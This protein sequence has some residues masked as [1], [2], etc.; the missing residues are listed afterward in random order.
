[1]CV[2]VFLFFLEPE[3]NISLGILLGIIPS[4]G[5]S[6]YVSTIIC[7]IDSVGVPWI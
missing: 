1:M 7:I 4:E 3:R 6:D 5:Y 2:Y